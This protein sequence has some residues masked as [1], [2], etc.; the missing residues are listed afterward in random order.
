MNQILVNPQLTEKMGRAGIA[1]SQKFSKQRTIAH[2]N[3]LYAK[4]VLRARH[5]PV[6]QK[7]PLTRSRFFQW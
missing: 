1:I 5:F 4:I 6:L 7:K 3:D 2:H